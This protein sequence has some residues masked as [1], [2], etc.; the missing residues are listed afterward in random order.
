VAAA[1]N[2]LYPSV[3]HPTDSG[4][5]AGTSVGAGVGWLVGDPARPGYV[6][7]SLNLFRGTV[8]GCG[9]GTM[10]VRST[11]ELV[12]MHLEQ[13]WEIVPGYGSGALVGAV[14][15]GTAKGEQA[16]DHSYAVD[17]IGRIDCTG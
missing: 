10:V 8:A 11:A 9:D 7:T 12:G 14:G 17:G 15:S 5:L 6:A 16:T 3:A 2:C 1:N 13:R 4:D